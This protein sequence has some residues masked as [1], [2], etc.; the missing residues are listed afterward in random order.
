MCK[1]IISLDDCDWD[2]GL[3]VVVI[4]AITATDLRLT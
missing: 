1:V 3:V 4:S 2:V